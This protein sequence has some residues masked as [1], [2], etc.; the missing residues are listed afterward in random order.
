MRPA[1]YMSHPRMDLTP[2]ERDV[3]RLVKT[4]MQTKEIA[5]ALQLREGT[6][7]YYLNRAFKKTGAHNRTELAYWAFT[8]PETPENA[9]TNHI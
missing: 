5:H 3:T 2:R 1:R 6:I 8:H 9:P 4:G 7:K